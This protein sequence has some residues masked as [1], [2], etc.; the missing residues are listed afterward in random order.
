MQWACS[1]EHSFAYCRVVTLLH[2]EAGLMQLHL[3]SSPCSD[4]ALASDHLEQ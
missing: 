3:N 4:F 2:G 1:L